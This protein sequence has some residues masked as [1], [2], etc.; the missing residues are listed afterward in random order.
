MDYLL[1][2]VICFGYGYVIGH[3]VGY[4]GKLDEY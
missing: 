4:E 1:L 3:S 2:A